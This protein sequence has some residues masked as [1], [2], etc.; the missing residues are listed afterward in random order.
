[1][2]LYYR[3]KNFFVYGWDNFRR[4]YQRFKRGWSYGDVWDMFDWFIGMAKPMLTH[5]RD[6][7]CGVPFEFQNNE[8]GWSAVLQEMIDCLE[9]MDEYNVYKYLG[10]VDQDGYK[11]MTCEDYKKVND[12]METNKNRFF[13]LFSK[14]F[15]SLWD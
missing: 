12:I 11:R 4:R 10:F 9:L 3:I 1:M 15:Y 7:H 5:L 2:R 14:Y 13:E 8:D 6:Y